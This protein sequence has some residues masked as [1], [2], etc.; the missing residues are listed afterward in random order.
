MT[1]K[2]R[3]T[4]RRKR[5]RHVSRAKPAVDCQRH[6]LGYPGKI[7]GKHDG[8]SEFPE[9]SRPGEDRAGDEAGGDQGQSDGPKYL[10]GRRSEIGRGGFDITI[11]PR[12]TASGG[13]DVERSRHEDLSHHDGDGGEP[14]RDSTLGKPLPDQSIST[15]GH[16]QRDA[17]YGRWQ[18]DRQIDKGF[19]GGGAGE[20]TPRQQIGQR[21]P[22]SD[23]DGHCHRRRRHAQ[24]ERLT[25]GVV[26]LRVPGSSGAKCAD[27]QRADRNG[28][29]QEEKEGKRPDGY[30]ARATA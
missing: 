10:A 19:D 29:E 20:A 9:G 17:R 22:Q 28:Q 5:R 6:R 16:E 27:N 12:K 15:K 3:T 25:Q 4:D 13:D 14:E 1:P 7:A 21:R 24:P 30:A 2:S 23:D 18:H 26:R 11:D 8:G